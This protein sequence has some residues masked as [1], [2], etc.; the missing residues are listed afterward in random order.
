MLLYFRFLNCCL[1]LCCVFSADRLRAQA[2][3][4]QPSS[5][6]CTSAVTG[7]TYD[8]EA[9]SWYSV[10]LAADTLF[11]CLAVTD[12]VQQRKLV[13]NGLEVWI[14]PKGKKNKKTGILYPFSAA[15]RPE[16]RPGQGMPPPPPPEEAVGFNTNQVPLLEKQVARQ[17]E[18]RLT[19]FKEDLNGIQNNFH[20]SGIRV[21]FSFV[22][23]TLLCQAQLPLNTLA[24]NGGVHSRWSVGL[25]EKGSTLNFFGSDPMPPGG[26]GEGM[27][28]PPGPPPGEE[29]GMRI[30]ED[31]IIWYR[32][33]AQNTGVAEKAM[34]AGSR[35]V[36]K[37]NNK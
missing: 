33:P 32:L 17:H 8:E 9:R 29:G 21:S 34:A 26:A 25:I 35:T 4:L 11:I 10:C 28:P 27:M 7:K 16:D 6:T 12:P 19:G 3:G 30:F 2:A 36:E 31:N 37:E 24:E 5:E 23:D 15:A 20:P 1:L 13:M 14:D 22:K 18:M